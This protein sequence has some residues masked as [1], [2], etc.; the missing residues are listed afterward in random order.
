MTLLTLVQ[1][2]SDTIGLPRPSAVVSSTD[3][4][5]RTLLSLA[6]TEGREL[7]ERFSWPATQLEATHTTLA[8]ELQGVMAT[9]AP[10]FGYIVNNTFWNRTLTEPV[11]GPLSPSEWQGLKARVATGPYSSYRLQ[12]GNL[13]AY[14]APSAGNTWAFEY[15]ST[16]FCQSSGGANQSAWAADT[17]VGILDENLM[18]LGV[19]W[20]FKKKNGLDYS[21]DYRTYEQK[22][23]NETARVGGKRTLVMNAGGG[24]ASGVFTPEGS[25]SV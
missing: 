12:G 10:G 8:A 16:Y 15:Q 18:E 21:E 2:A 1:N 5:V 25:W 13:Y 4:N 11:P 20:R 9:I 14:P 23:A 7:L 17:D 6:Q 24:Y 19:V 3:G 22:L